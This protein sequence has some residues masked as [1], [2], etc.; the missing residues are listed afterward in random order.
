MTVLI[1]R[2]GPSGSAHGRRVAQ[3]ICPLYRRAIAETQRE[4]LEFT[5]Q[6]RRVGAEAG[7]GENGRE[8]RVGLCVEEA[9][10]ARRGSKRQR[11]L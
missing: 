7:S 6:A 2:E 3:R 8:R 5:A 4:G 10:V 1:Q 11:R 9:C